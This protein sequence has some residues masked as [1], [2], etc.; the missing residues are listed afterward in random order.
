MYVAVG[1][2]V[3]VTVLLAALLYAAA[4]IYFTQPDHND[5]GMLNE[6]W[7]ADGFCIVNKEIPY[8]S[9]FDTC[10]YVDVIFSAILAAMWWMW[11]NVPGMKAIETT[12]LMMIVSTT[13]HG[14]AH[15]GMAVQFR[16]GNYEKDNTENEPEIPPWPKQLVFCGLFWFPLLKA[17]MPKLNSLVVAGVALIAT[18]GPVL[19]GGL[20]KQ[21]GFAYIQ[22]IVS[23]AFHMSQ[24]TLPAEEKRTRQYMTLPI[25]G[26]VPV[27]VAWNEALF[28]SSHTLYD[29]S[30]I[31]SFI[32][33]YVDTYRYNASTGKIG[34]ESGKEKAL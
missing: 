25:T 14:L 9:S 10:L 20:R 32:V 6:Q 30:I 11:R 18:F 17:S 29:A 34:A 8:W 27:I 23:I 2:A 19:A 22:T 24:L 16:E 28:C 3:N 13:A 33:M 21:L 12:T 26:I 1:N 31:L 7:K 4:V 15:G 5:R